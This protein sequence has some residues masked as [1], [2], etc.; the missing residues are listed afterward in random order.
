MK[1]LRKN[2][3]FFIFII[4]IIPLVILPSQVVSANQED[5]VLKGNDVFEVRDRVF[6]VVGN[7]VLRDNATVIVENG[8]L[9][10]IQSARL[11]YNYTLMDRSRLILRKSSHLQIYIP[12]EEIDTGRFSDRHPVFL[13]DESTLNI[14]DS[15]V[16]IGIVAG[17]HSLIYAKNAILLSL[18]AFGNTSVQLDGT[19]VR[20][21]GLGEDGGNVEI[22]ELAT[23][24]IINSSMRELVVSGKADVRVENSIVKTVNAGTELL[25]S[26]VTLWIFDSPSGEEPGLGLWHS[27]T[28]W[29]VNSPLTE[30]GISFWSPES[31]LIFGWYLDVHVNSDNQPVEGAEVEVYYAHNGSIATKGTTDSDG[32]VRFILPE[33]TL[34]KYE[35][36]K[37]GNYNVKASFNDVHGEEKVTLD[38]SKQITVNLVHTNPPPFYTTPLGIGTLVIVALIAGIAISA[39][40]FRK[41]QSSV[42]K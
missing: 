25:D 34:R 41:K 37:I 9:S 7:V 2:L 6:N 28:I 18:G 15:S 8:I 26:E 36:E 23:A 40:I 39:I 19:E 5:F 30:S 20:S 1:I 35:G 10:I 13:R 27:S 11:Q 12:G 21:I 38:S 42:Q 24:R 16:H 14:S 4:L 22:G 31:L 3:I 32:N 29:L 17:P 33:K